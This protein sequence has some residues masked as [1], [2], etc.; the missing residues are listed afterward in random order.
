MNP[1]IQTAARLIYFSMYWY[2]RLIGSLLHAALIGNLNPF[3]HIVCVSPWTRSTPLRLSLNYVQ[4]NLCIISRLGHYLHCCFCIIN[5]D[6][7][8]LFPTIAVQSAKSIEIR[9]YVSR[10][11]QDDMH[12]QYPTCIYK[13]TLAAQGHKQSGQ[14]TGTHGIQQQQLFN[15]PQCSPPTLRPL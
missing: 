7:F 14:P 3:E 2:W 13:L 6:C 5:I 10:E 8:L 9:W 12:T 4:S 11:I 1:F 15:N